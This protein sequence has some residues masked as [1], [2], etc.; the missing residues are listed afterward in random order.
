MTDTTPL[1]YDPVGGTLV[2][3]HAFDPAAPIRTLD[4]VINAIRSKFKAHLKFQYRAFR[5]VDSG[6]RMTTVELGRWNPQARVF[7]PIGALVLSESG[8]R[9]LV[10]Q[11][12]STLAKHGDS[13]AALQHAIDTLNEPTVGKAR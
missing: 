5:V 4:D 9:V 7:T 3:S 12:Q 8:L 11:L 1:V 13:D 6:N 10:D 2:E